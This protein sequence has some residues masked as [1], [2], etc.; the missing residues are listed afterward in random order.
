MKVLG[1]GRM[2]IAQ[3]NALEKYVKTE[4]QHQ[5]DKEID[6]AEN[7]G[8]FFT[9]VVACE[10]L[11]EVF[12]FG[13]TRRVRFLDE[14]VKKCNELAEYLKSNTCI[15]GDSDKPVID[16]DYNLEFLNRYAARFGLKSDEGMIE[17]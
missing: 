9:T 4:V 13:E 17:Y 6:N 16:N 7:F 15:E 3:R 5:Y 8:K 14:Y 12:G 10:V 11:E 1:N 2:S